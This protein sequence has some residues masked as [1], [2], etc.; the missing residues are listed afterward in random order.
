MNSQPTESELAALDARLS[1]QEGER[2]N[3][4]YADRGRPVPFFGTRA[5]ENLAQWVD[6]GTMV[7]GRALDLGC[8]NGRNAVF[9]ASHGFA[10]QGIDFSEAAIA[11]ARDQAANAGVQVD[12]RCASVF[13]VDIAPASCDLVYD[14]GCFHHM[15]PHRR[16]DYMALVARALKPGGWFGMTCFRPE[17][18]SGLTDEQVYEQGSLRG[19]LGY[20]EQQLRDHWSTALEVTEVRQMKELPATATHFG[21]DFLWVLLGRTPGL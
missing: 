19:G 9:L 18:G 4:F 2:W 16:Q 6:D 11:W 13:D 20:T 12:L 21:K 15:A 1:D 10:V 17:G 7:P 3:R 14:S 8:G 5:D